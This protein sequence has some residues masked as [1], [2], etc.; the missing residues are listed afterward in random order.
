MNTKKLR[1]PDGEEKLR[2]RNRSSRKRGLG[3]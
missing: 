1:R 2:V 3:A